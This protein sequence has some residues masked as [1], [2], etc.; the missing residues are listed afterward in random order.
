MAGQL[1]RHTNIALA[2]LQAVDGANVVQA[3]TGH[4]AARRCV[5]TGHHP[6]R[7]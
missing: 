2:R 6:A 4:V 7:A 1:A 5:G 3:A